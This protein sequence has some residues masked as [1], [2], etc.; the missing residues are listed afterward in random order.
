MFHRFFEWRYFRRR[1]RS[2]RAAGDAM[3]E[4]LAGAHAFRRA[5]FGKYESFPRLRRFCILA[6]CTG[7]GLALLWFLLESARALPLFD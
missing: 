7:A 3:P 5:R 2:V 4:P 6:A 1:R